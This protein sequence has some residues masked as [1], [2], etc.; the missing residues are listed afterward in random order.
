ML[1][2]VSIASLDVICNE[3]SIGVRYVGVHMLVCMSLLMSLCIST[4][5]NALL[6]LSCVFTC[7]WLLLFEDYCNGIVYVV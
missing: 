7:W 6:M 2:Y 4:V 1:C 5:S 3:L